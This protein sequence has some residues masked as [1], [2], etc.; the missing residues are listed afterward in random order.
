MNAVKR[1]TNVIETKCVRMKLESGQLM[2]TNNKA[3]VKWVVV[4]LSLS[5]PKGGGVWAYS[6]AFRLY[7]ESGFSQ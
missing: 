1:R 5:P 3:F 2:V 7:S 4:S 6:K